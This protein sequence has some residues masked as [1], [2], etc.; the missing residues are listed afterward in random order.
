[1]FPGQSY[2]F[3]ASIP[4]S[5]NAIVAPPELLDSGFFMRWATISGM[6]SSLSFKVGT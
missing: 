1:M 2:D 5:S 4:L 3:R 6:S